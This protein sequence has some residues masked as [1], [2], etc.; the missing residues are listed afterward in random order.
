MSLLFSC[1]V[2][3][4][5]DIPAAESAAGVEQLVWISPGELGGKSVCGVVAVRRRFAAGVSSASEGLAA[6]NKPVRMLATASA[7]HCIYGRFRTLS[8]SRTPRL[9]LQP[10]RQTGVWG[11][12]ACTVASN[13]WSSVISGGR[14][15]CG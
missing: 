5:G 10:I 3:P 6:P 7:I 9:Q 4:R 13:R 8:L 14:L 11:V 1:P 12:G 2:V 15:H